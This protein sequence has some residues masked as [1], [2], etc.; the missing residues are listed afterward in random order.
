MIASSFL[1]A[2]L[3][4]GQHD[5]ERN[6][7][8]HLAEGEIEK[9]YE[10]LKNGEKHTDPAEMGFLST[11]CLLKEGKTGQALKMAKESVRLG[12]PFG[13]FL[14]EPL[15]WLDPL[16]NHPGFKKWK[17]EINPSPLVHGP[18]LGQVTDT[19]ASFWFR[20]DGPREVAVVV[21]GHSTRFK[22]KTTREN[23]F[24]GTVEIDG[25]LPGTYFSYEVFVDDE[26]VIDS[27]DDFGFRTFPSSGEDSKFTL[28][29]GGCSGFV[30]EYE[31]TWNLIADHEPRAT[32][33]LGDNVYIDDPEEVEWTGS[34]CYSRRHSRPEWKKLIARSSIHAIY[35]DH[36]FG[37]DDC[38]PGDSV[39]LPEWKKSVFA[40][41]RNNWNNP[42]M[43][44][45]QENPGCWHTFSLGKVQVIM[46][47]C[48]YYRDL[49]EKSMLGSVQ[50][51]WLKNTLRESSATFKVIASSVPFSEG[52]KP[53]SKDPWDGYA[54]EREEIFSFIE[55][56][57]IEGVFL[58]AADRHRID[59]RK[60]TRS[61][62][63]D[64]YEFVSGRLT[65]RHIHPVIETDGLIWGYN[66]TCGYCLLHFDTQAKDPVLL[67]EAYDIDAKKLF[68]YE[69]KASELRVED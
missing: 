45:G 36:D 55:N 11:L 49:H 20:T 69:I 25:L 16:R 24:V 66:E 54:S 34:Y 46:L 39:N 3:C 47:D 35:D 32:L 31:K 60:T 40:N 9:A 57:K 48:R 26:Q 62:G 38:I 17:S 53:G 56:Q 64:L 23:R 10:E 58:I 7:F 4:F 51:K 37:T 68:S 12:L 18:M 65:N 19:V 43:G 29:F 30:P 1:F 50:K 44:G 5:R 41:F 67:L 15:D 27:G 28:A 21:P 22:M 52:V 2:G 59:L 6:A 14:A 33:L 61:E 42:P 13:R 63:Y 8:R